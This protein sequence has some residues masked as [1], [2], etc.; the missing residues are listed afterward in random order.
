MLSCWKI[1]NI[2]ILVLDRLYYMVRITGNLSSYLNISPAIVTKYWCVLPLRV[3]HGWI[4]SLCKSIDKFPSY[5]RY[6]DG[7][8]IILT[9]CPC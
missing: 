6:I 8:A 2:F 1:H 4:C 7:I 3:L 5:W 9:N